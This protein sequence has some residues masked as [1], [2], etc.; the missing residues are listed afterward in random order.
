MFIPFSFWRKEVTHIYLA[1]PCEMHFFKK[2]FIYL[3]EREREYKQGRLRLPAE[4][5]GSPDPESWPE[6]KAD[7]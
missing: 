4:P 1:Q 7:T 2:D 5:A 3:T 6:L